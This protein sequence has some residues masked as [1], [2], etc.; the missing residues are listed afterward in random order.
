MRGVRLLTA[1]LA[2]AGAA[3]GG[4]AAAQ[5]EVSAIPPLTAY[6]ALP[7]VS[8]VSI[9]PDGATLAY[10][11]R[12]GE[13]NRV[14]AQTRGGEVLAAV[15]T[16]IINITGVRW[17]SNDHVAVS[18]VSTEHS[19][20]GG[21]QGAYRAVEILNVRTRGYERVLRRADHNA[22]NTVYQMSRG[23]YRGQ[24]VAWVVAPTYENG[25]LTTDVYR[26][27]LDTG[28]GWRELTGASDTR[29]YVLTRDGQAI[30]RQA[31]QADNGLYRLSA[32]TGSGWREIMQDRALLDA[33]S[34]WG[35]GR[36][37]DTLLVSTHVE[38]GWRTRE[39]SLATGEVGDTLDSE[40]SIDSAIY[41]PD[42][43]L[44]AI[45]YTD[46]RQEYEIFRPELAAV[47][48]TLKATFPPEAQLTFVS[49]SDDYK[50]VVLYVEAPGETGGYY[51]FDADRQRLSIVGRA[52]PG[53]PGDVVGE[54]RLIRYTA[55]DGRQL[56]GYL[57]LPPG[58][59][60]RNL[61]VVMLPHGGP[62]SRDTAGF[63]WLAQG[64]ASR[65]Y[66][67]FQP[68]F[69]GSA[70]FGDDL[71]RAGYGEWGRKM[72]S[73]V[74]DGLRY[75]AAQGI[76]DPSR[77]CIV[78][79]SYGG[80]AA[81]AGMTLE[82]G[83]YRCGVSIAGI[84]DLQAMLR[85]TER[86]D[87][88]RGDENAAIRYWKRFMGVDGSNDPRL[89]TLSPARLVTPETGP[90]LLIHGR[91]DTVVPFAQ[92]ELMLRALGGEGERAHLAALS[93]QNH[94]LSDQG[95]GERLQMLTET[96]AFLARHNPAD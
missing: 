60:T 51:L 73:D 11:R 13:Q 54:V 9:S 55:A 80:Y 46:L 8:N 59:A 26:I 65:G 14:I 35:L 25:D 82:A 47:W 15:E 78:G 50:V 69:R 42:G 77:A 64:I 28:R 93:G 95:V 18:R 2:M 76:V 1:I 84:S 44:A 43:T 62:E 66:A 86:R 5:T 33:P 32:R 40:H 91:N 57:T 63:D 23:V 83:T 74:S 58:R 22:I 88:S 90:I 92:S 37:A 3:F 39:V 31:Y 70:G 79:W 24:P 53:V 56:V 12:E 61:P 30:A 36:T 4:I 7:A 21:F 81:L 38:N 34:V 10:V 49:A 20:L 75:L 16:G 94:S 52:Y 67:V 68:Q 96:T 29:S 6:A 19:P 17:L 27:E 48:D 71:T 72:Q 87:Y 41:A 89:V 45:G 85:D